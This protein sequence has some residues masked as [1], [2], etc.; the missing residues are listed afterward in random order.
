MDERSAC[1]RATNWADQDA[2]ERCVQQAE[3]EKERHDVTRKRLVTLL[4]GED[5]LDD[6]SEPSWLRGLVADDAELST[7]GEC[8]AREELAEIGADLGIRA[9]QQEG[10]ERKSEEEKIEEGGEDEDA[11][12]KQ[13]GLQRSVSVVRWR[14][15]VKAAAEQR[16]YT[17]SVQ[18]CPM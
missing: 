18:R 9:E 1:G 13:R 14:W 8:A 6:A 3:D 16:L 15:K 5:L 10:E 7:G 11:R 2:P 17:F 12:G 4:A